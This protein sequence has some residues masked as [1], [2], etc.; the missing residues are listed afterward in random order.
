MTPEIWSRGSLLPYAKNGVKR[1]LRKTADAV[2]PLV[3]RAAT[4]VPKP[5]AA[6][7][8][9]NADAD[10]DAFIRGYR[11]LERVFPQ[12]DSPGNGSAKTAPS[13]AAVRLKVEA[14]RGTRDR[15]AMVTALAQGADLDSALVRCMRG[16]IKNGDAAA[17]VAVGHSLAAKSDTEQL[18]CVVLGMG[19]LSTS[20][21]SNAWKVFSGLVHAKSV[22]PAAHEFYAAAF[23]A[24]GQAAGDILAEDL[25][26][27][28]ADAWDSPAVLHIAQKALAH[29]RFDEVRKLIALGLGRPEG[30]MKPFNRK[31]FIRL[32]TWLPEGSHRQ[33]VEAADGDFTFGVVSYQQPDVTS[34]NIGDYIQTV[35]SLGHLVRQRNFTFSGDPELVEFVDE[36]RASSKPE[37]VVDGPAARVNLVELYRDGNPLQALPKPTWAVTYGWYMHH[38][39]EQGFNIPFHEN[40]RPII[41]SMFVR[42][43]EMLTP[44]AVDYLRKYA[45]VGC[46][47]WQ[48]VALLR[49]AGVPAF[50]SGCITTTIDTVF[51]RDDAD[52][53]DATIYV[54]SP[55]TGP[56]V[57]RRQ[58][59]TGIRDLS[60]V[61]NLRKARDWVSHYHETYDKVVTSR[62]H[63]FLP[64]RS[65][66]SSVTF[67][68][69]N[70]SD[71]RFGGLIDTSDAEFNAIRDG[72][73]KKVSSVVQALASGMGEQEVYALWRELCA[74]DMAVADAR[75]AAE[76]LPRADREAVEALAKAAVTPLETAPEGSMHLVVDCRRNEADHLVPLLK[77][78]QDLASGPVR[79]WITGDAASED[80]RRAVQTAVPEADIQWLDLST[81]LL[82]SVAP[83]LARGK[84][85]ELLLALVPEVLHDVD[86]A[87]FL[88]AA[89]L[90]R[91]DVGVLAGQGPG[92]GN[93][94][95]ARDDQHLGRGSGFALLRRVA[96][97]Q[98]KDNRKAL[99]FTFAA[100]GI[101]PSDFPT[102]D[103]N[104][105]VA[106]LRAMRT[107]GLSCQAMALIAVYGASFREA[108]NAIV[109]AARR[110][111]PTEWNH[112]PGYERQ[113]QPLLVNWRDTSKP[114]SSSFTPFADEW[115][116]V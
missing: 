11:A 67:L 88:P 115:A 91:G 93:M 10:A 114:W 80:E 45:P 69:K 22:R 17:A 73:L 29:D 28:E 59:Q 35:A 31:E 57:F 68:P 53:R 95:A 24:L 18:G 110:E 5:V 48:T 55:K 44:E 3:R 20:G 105:M 34:R 51:R 109:G 61:D 96:S 21:P 77:S 13:D 113:Q 2:L 38:T 42:Y 75:L 85:H 52:D 62:L 112:V 15:A 90:L 37:R 12:A 76:R 83:E 107:A 8:V 101:H 97:R 74:P 30:S 54:D 49:A 39:F 27:G 19:L 108:L 84:R 43:P 58:A 47:D 99:Q 26:A 82:R 46:R 32:R 81:E 86:T 56:G 16:M 87:I 25:R 23:G 102:F 72:I 64:A 36:L 78:G 7:P 92:P 116:R 1:S 104:V 103:T 98:G 14:A 89:A 71:T 9:P 63:C 66:G 6:A 33:A 111:L 79:W 106:D 100:L 4:P 50:F 60:F 40:L 70:R 41:L 65:V 94:L